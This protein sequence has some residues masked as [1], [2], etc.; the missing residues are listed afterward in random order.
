[1]MCSVRFRIVFH[2][3]SSSPPLFRFPEDVGQ[4]SELQAENEARNE[5]FKTLQ[6]FDG[7]VESRPRRSRKSDKYHSQQEVA[8]RPDE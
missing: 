3:A 2:P 4:V 1:M 6:K 5:Q 7:M 8:G